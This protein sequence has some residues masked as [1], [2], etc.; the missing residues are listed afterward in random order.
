MKEAQAINASLSSLG[1]V[2]TGLA[3]KAAHIPYRDS[4]LTFLLSESLKP[5]SKVLMFVNLAPS[6]ADL[7]ES[8]SSLTFA[9]RVNSVELGQ[10]VQ[11]TKPLASS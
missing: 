2:I 8:I 11:F 10:A 9:Q 1:Q 6:Q 4:K 5:G 3:S 7:A